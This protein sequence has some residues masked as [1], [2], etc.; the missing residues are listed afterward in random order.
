MEEPA[1]TPLDDL[2]LRLNLTNDDLVTASTEQLTFKQVHKA[3][4]GRKITVNIQGKI[5]RA[6]KACATGSGYRRRDIFPR[7]GEQ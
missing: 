5:M 1:P 4:A 6:L 3:R 7:E 2:L